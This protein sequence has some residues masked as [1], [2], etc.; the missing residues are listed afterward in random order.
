MELS[1]LTRAFAYLEGQGYR[2]FLVALSVLSWCCVEDQ[3]SLDPEEETLWGARLLVSE[4]VKD[5]E[6]LLWG[7]QGDTLKKVFF[8]P[9]SNT[10][11]EVDIDEAPRKYLNAG[12]GKL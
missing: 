1:G 12:P 2:P 7:R 3:V 8:Y 11:L 5:G 9:D 4:E 6:I 10:A